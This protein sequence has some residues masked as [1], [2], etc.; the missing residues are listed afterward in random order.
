MIQVQ[1][2]I[3]TYPGATEPTLKGLNF[4]VEKGAIFGFLGPSGAGKSTAQKV[5]YKIL[6]GYKGHITVRDKELNTWDKSYFDDIGVG[7]ELPNHYLKLSAVE[8]LKLFASFYDKSRLIPID[9]LFQRVG[10][11]GDMDKPVEAYSKGMKMRLNFIRAIQHDPEILFFDEP[12]AGLDP[13]NAKNIRNQIR[14]LKDRGKTIFIT[15]HSMHT[16]DELCD[17]VA[18]IAD[19]SIRIIDTPSNLKRQYGKAAVQVRTE[20]EGDREFALKD[21]GTNTDFL[22]YLKNNTIR[23]I[24]TLEASLDEV[25][26]EVTGKSLTP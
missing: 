2:L 6:K 13:V 18:F 4:Q 19:G 3:Y 23:S 14:E 16:A 8:N 12:T 25:F 10:L 26:I 5:L 22:Q 24:R 9:D 20:T 7:F 1:D 17:E 21:L 11:E 15:T